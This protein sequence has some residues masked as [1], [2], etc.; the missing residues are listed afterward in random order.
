MKTHDVNDLHLDSLRSQAER[1]GLLKYLDPSY[2]SS[3]DK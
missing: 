3:Q 1:L 2:D